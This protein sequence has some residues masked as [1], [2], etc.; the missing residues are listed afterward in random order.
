MEAILQSGTESSILIGLMVGTV[1]FIWS[2]S[3]LRA[4]RREQATRDDAR[5][6]QMVAI[7]KEVVAA[8]S[9]NAASQEKLA[10]VLDK[11][12]NKIDTL[13]T[14]VDVKTLEQRMVSLHTVT[15]DKL[16]TIEKAVIK[17]K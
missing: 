2:F 6:E 16:D 9:T 17:K 5:T 11:N 8:I 7:T 14:R 1:M 12:V 4:D 13:P 3:Q 10:D 15:H